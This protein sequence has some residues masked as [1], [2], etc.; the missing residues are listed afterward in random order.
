MSETKP[1]TTGNLHGTD[2][3]DTKKADTPATK[4]VESA[5]KGGVTARKPAPKAAD[6]KATDDEPAPKTD[7][8]YPSQ[9]DLD[10]MREGKFD[11]R[12]RDVKAEGGAAEYKTR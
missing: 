4:P 5:E 7:D 12:R 10:A 3:Q 11:H 9:V 2:Q 1:M 6:R 8:P